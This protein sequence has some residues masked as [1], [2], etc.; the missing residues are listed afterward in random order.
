MWNR[1]SS[2]LNNHVV[3]RIASMAPPSAAR[4]GDRVYWGAL[5]TGTFTV[6]SAYHVLM[7]HSLV[8]DSHD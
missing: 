7:N 1:F 8:E 5:N 2:L 6:H 4:G 3:L